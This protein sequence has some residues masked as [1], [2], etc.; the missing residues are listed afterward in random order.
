[1][2]A[3]T[4]SY[5]HP[6]VVNGIQQKD[7][8]ADPKGKEIPTRLILHFDINETILLGD[9]AGGDTR[10]ES[11]NK[12]LAKSAF[13]Q[14]PPTSSSTSWE[15]TTQITPTH[16][17]DGQ[18]I[19]KETS[20]PPLY[21]G[22]EW[23]EG[24][25]PY[26]R[27]SYKK[28]SKSFVEHHG[29]KV[30]QGLLD[31]CEAKLAESK[32]SKDHILP[33]LYQT[34]DQMMTNKT[35]QPFTVVFRTFGSDLPDIAEALTE[36]ATGRHPDFPDTNYPTLCLSKEC[37]YQGR[38]KETDSGNVY[39]L[40]DYDGTKIVASGDHAILKLLDTIPI[41]GI[42]DHYTHW[43]RNDCDPKAGKPVWVP[44]DP[45]NN[46]DVYDHHILFDDNIHNLAHDGIACVRREQKD[47]SFETVDSNVMHKDYQGL[48]L[49]RVPTI[50][51]VLNPNWFMEQ[52]SKAQSKLQRQ[53]K[54]NKTV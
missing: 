30:Y 18:E 43:A 19:G 7:E 20:T 48:N 33:A 35:K 44:R 21:T 27:T 26:Y 36:F 49:I 24:C 8:R 3:T 13:V 29:R 10:H 42:Q 51:P 46:T 47:G 22:W 5:S 2:R 41:C 23:P 25:C 40:W 31:E 37:L 52:V 9:E 15:D 32:S 39:Q 50:E 12:M 17:W 1:M 6:L 34:L 16:W 45:T 38:W 14:L 28:I 54:S 11:V 4:Y 53:L